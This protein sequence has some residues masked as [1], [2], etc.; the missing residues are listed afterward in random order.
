M[1]VTHV[2]KHV[3]LFVCILCTWIG[4]SQKKALVYDDFEG[5]GPI[6][7]W[8]YA[9][10]ESELKIIEDRR[11]LGNHIAV[12]NKNRYGIKELYHGI[13]ADFSE[14]FSFSDHKQFSVRLYVPR[15]SINYSL[16]TKTITLKLMVSKNGKDLDD[17]WSSI[18]K[19]FE[20]GKWQ[21][22]VFDLDGPDVYNRNG[23]KITS[24]KDFNK[25]A[26]EFAPNTNTPA[27]FYIDNFSF[28]NDLKKAKP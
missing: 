27:K 4:T 19:P 23:K 28:G 15:T 18:T 5:G 24:R 26:L 12:F 7:W 1:T 8:H 13:G 11:K 10:S 20:I 3:T 2:Y 14:K 22:I 16:K 9:D 17:R 25:I 21:T 6:D